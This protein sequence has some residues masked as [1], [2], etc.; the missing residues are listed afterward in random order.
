MTTGTLLTVDG[1]ATLRFERRLPHD[2]GKV[3]RSLTEPERLATWFPC[4]VEVD[5]VVGGTMLFTFEG[6]EG[7][8]LSGEVLELDPPRTFAYT[9]GED[10]LRF[11]LRPGANGCVLVFTHTFDDRAKSA[12]D[13]VG[14]EVCLGTLDASLDG[15]DFDPPSDFAAMHG[16]YAQKFGRGAHM[17]ELG[18]FPDAR[19]FRFERLVP[20][21][22]HRV[23]DHLT[24]P[25]LL[26]TWLA[27]AEIEPHINGDV[28][29]RIV[30]D[31]VP[32]RKLSGQVVP[33]QRPGVGRATQALLHMDRREHIRLCGELRPRG[34]GRGRRRAARPDPSRRPVRAE[35]RGSIGVPCVPQCA[36]GALARRSARA[37]RNGDQAR[38]AGLRAPRH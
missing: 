24:K 29:L 32:E 34:R 15:R 28:V 31:H 30:I 9:W 23:W 22:A 38:G 12:R 16:V 2:V 5:L 37:V 11:E 14:W 6:D 35:S 33:R 19:T 7:P 3:W 36:R 1:R 17:G 18:T 26:E 27:V 4:R 10:T 20:G 25:E 8:P 13:A 21:P